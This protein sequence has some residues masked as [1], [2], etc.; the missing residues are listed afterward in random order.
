MLMYKGTG[1]LWAGANC[2]QRVVDYAYLVFRNADSTREGFRKVG[3]RE[4]QPGF[5]HW[6]TKAPEESLTAV[7]LFRNQFIQFIR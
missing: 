2:V 5:A 1:N 3:L 6:H 4:Q 7:E